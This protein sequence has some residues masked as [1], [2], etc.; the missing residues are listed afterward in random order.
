LFLDGLSYELGIDFD[1]GVGTNFQSFD[2]I[3]QP[4]GDHS[5]GDNSTAQGAGT[6]AVNAGDYVNLI[7]SNNLAQN[8]GN[9]E[10]FDNG[11]FPFDANADGLYDIYLLARD[12]Q[13]GEVSRVD[14]QVIVGNGAVEVAEP[15]ILAVL[16][17]GLAG[18]GL[19]R[20]RQRG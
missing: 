2:P 6:E 4:N 18:L 19:M 20:R 1:A 10:F 11:A 12:G 3:N 16:G 9:M 5:I 14:I 17:L 7:G 13:G 15:G 8:S